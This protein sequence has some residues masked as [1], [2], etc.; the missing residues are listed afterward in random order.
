M[1]ITYWMTACVDLIF[2]DILEYHG[3]RETPATLKESMIIAKQIMKEYNFKHAVIINA[4]TGEILLEME[5]D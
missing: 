2:D 5:K 1:K 4:E 3:M